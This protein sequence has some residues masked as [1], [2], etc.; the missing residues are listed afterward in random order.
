MKNEYYNGITDEDFVKYF[1]DI[2]HYRVELTQYQYPFEQIEPQE[3]I[4]DHIVRSQR[5]LFEYILESV[6]ASVYQIDDK[7][8]EDETI[9]IFNKKK[10]KILPMLTGIIGNYSKSVKVNYINL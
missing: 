6:R 8:E 7:I 3:A 9:F 2:L 1:E 4:D 5:S 10:A